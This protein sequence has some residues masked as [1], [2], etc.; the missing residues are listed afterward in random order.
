MYLGSATSNWK[1]Y[2][3]GKPDTSDRNR[4]IGNTISYTGAESIDIKEGSTGGIIANNRFDGT[5][6]SGENYADSW[7]DVKGNNYTVT[8]NS[9][10]NSILDGIQVHNVVSGWGNNNVFK[11]NSVNV[12]GPGVGFNIQ[13]KAVGTVV[14][15]DNTV[16]SAKGGFGN[17]T[18]RN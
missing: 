2:S 4:V 8:G 3:N 15:C 17:I 5:N 11:A 9:G 12:N 13:S 14:Y 16:S 7:L 18:C 1:T 10:A 6:M